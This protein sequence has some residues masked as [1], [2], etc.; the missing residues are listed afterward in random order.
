MNITRASLCFGASTLVLSFGSPVHAEDDAMQ[1]RLGPVAFLE[2]REIGPAEVGG[3]VS[4]I[5][6]DDVLPSDSML[7][8]HDGVPFYSTVTVV[9]ESPLNPN[10]LYTGSDDGRVMGTQDSGVTWLDLTENIRDLPSNTY[11]SRIVASNAEEGRVYATFDGHYSGDF[12]PYVYVSDN[13]GDRWRSITDGLPQTSVNVLTEHPDEGKL[14]FLGNEVGVFV[15]LD[16]G[17]RWDPLMNGLPTVPVADIRVHPDYDYLLIGTHGRGLWILN[18][19]APLKQLSSGSVI[20]GT[21]YLFRGGQTIQWRQRSIQDWTASD[22]FRLPNPR[23]GARI[24]Y[25]IPEGFDMGSEESGEE[26]E[27]QGGDEAADDDPQ[28]KIKILTATGQDV[29]TIEGPATP[30]AHEVLWD[31]RM[32]PAYQPQENQ[33]AGGRGGAYSIGARGPTVLPSVYQIQID[34]G[35]TTMFGDL[36]VRQDPRID[37]SRADLAARQ[38]AMMSMYQ[39]QAPVYHAGQALRRL[40]LQFSDV[41]QFLQETSAA[42]S[43]SIELE[44]IEEELD[45]VARELHRLRPA[46]TN[47]QIEASTTRPTEDQLQDVE[48]AWRD[49][50]E[51]IG[52]LNALILVRIPAL[53]QKLNDERFPANPGEYLE[54]PRRRG[55]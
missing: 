48:R 28:L 45:D 51:V 49:I 4:D 16:G 38:A 20:I 10:L 19:I 30:G 14:L 42:E 26:P 53:Y 36:T 7:A 15:S 35:R 6:I 23:V 11:V 22:E 1:Q 54:T 24:R 41:E 46:N 29:R 21:P 5:A 43:F 52:R 18:D 27:N 9:A 13:Y 37:V 3:R 47:Q 34:V 44:G 8:H 55:G 17:D 39:L 12:A 32:D 25:W 2:W 33:G 31:F 50:P 40:N